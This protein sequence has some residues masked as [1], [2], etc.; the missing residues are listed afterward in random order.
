MNSFKEIERKF[1]VRKKH[2]P[3]NYDKIEK[4]K[5]GYIFNEKKGILRIREKDNIYILTIKLKTN[6]IEERTEIEKE[7]TKEEFEIL[8][9]SIDDKNKIIKTRKIINNPDGTKWEIDFFH[10]LKDKYENLILAEIELNNS[11]QKFKKPKWLYKEV[12]NNLEYYNNNLI[13][14]VKTNQNNNEIINNIGYN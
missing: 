1:L 9:N 2:L 11:K 7:L 10:N 4:I 5:Q 8:W 3:K 14:Y 6:K 12:T 13:K